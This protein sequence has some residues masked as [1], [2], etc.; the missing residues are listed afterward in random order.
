VANAHVYESDSTGDLQ[1]VDLDDLE[2][3]RAVLA[4]RLTS[5]QRQGEWIA[6]KPGDAM[7]EDAMYWTAWRGA[8]SGID[9]AQCL[10][11]R[12]MYW[13]RNGVFAYL[14]RPLPPP[15]AGGD[16]GKE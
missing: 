2:H 13:Q 16:G 14:P 5:P 11:L 10:V 1:L 6:W 3:A 9:L 4:A 12:P 8:D 7:P 15:P